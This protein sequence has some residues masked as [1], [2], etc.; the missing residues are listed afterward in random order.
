MV[1]C[2][3]EFLKFSVVFLAG[4]GM[5]SLPGKFNL[6]FARFA[7]QARR[8]RELAELGDKQFTVGDHF[9]PVTSDVVAK[10]GLTCMDFVYF[11]PLTSCLLLKIPFLLW[12]LKQ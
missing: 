6:F 8:A 12:H 9:L 11:R 2:Q 5:L 3:L 1:D 7:S 4:R 10:R